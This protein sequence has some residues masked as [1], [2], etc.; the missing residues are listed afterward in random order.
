MQ[1]NMQVTHTLTKDFMDKVM[2]SDLTGV[3]KEQARIGIP[4]SYLIDDKLNQNALFF[5]TLNKSEDNALE[6]LD[7][8]IT[9][10]HL[11]PLATDLLS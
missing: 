3:K 9:N 2:K 10:A 7:Y 11:D 6:I 4:A 1:Q 5:A 8:L